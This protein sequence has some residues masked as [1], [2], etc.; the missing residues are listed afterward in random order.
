MAQ[1][2]V[3]NQPDPAAELASM[4]AKYPQQSVILEKHTLDVTIEMVDGKPVFE[5]D[6]YTSFFILGDNTTYMADSKEYFSSKEEVKKIEAYSLVPE[7]G[8]YKELS[9]NKFT[10][11]SEMGDGVFFDDQY[12]YSYTFP[13]VVKGVKTVSHAQSVSSDC[14]MPIVFYFGRSLPVEDSRITITCPREVKLITQLFGYDTTQVKHEVITKGNLTIHTWQA[15]MPKSYLHDALAP[16]VQHYTPHLVVNVDSYVSNGT[17]THV[18]GNTAD[19]YRHNYSKIENVNQ[20]IVPEIQQLAD[21]ITSS[22]ATSRDKVK[23]IYRWVQQNIKYVAIEDGENGMVPREA[24]LVLQRRYGDCKDKS[25]I[26]VS[27]M[28]AVHLN[29]SMVWVGTRDLPYSYKTSPSILVDNHMIACWWDENNQPVLLDGTSLYHSVGE[30]PAFIQGKECLIE[31]GKD[32]FMVYT[33]PVAPPKANLTVDSLVLTI[34]H[35]SIV[36][37]G[38]ATFH[39]EEKT[40]MMH[41]FAGRDPKRFN[42][43]VLLRCPKATNKYIVNKTSVSDCQNNDQ[44][45]TINYDF[46]LPD[47]IGSSNGNRYVNLNLDRPFQN[48]VINPDRWLPVESEYTFLKRMVCILNVPNDYAISQIPDASQYSNELFG[49]TQTYQQ[50][51]NQ[52]ILTTNI[53]LNF[54]ILEGDEVMQFRDMIAKLNRTC[55]KSI[56]LT[57]K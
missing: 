47:Y 28:K 33:I 36:G 23:A 32:D 30:I 10:K 43:I 26:L 40:N 11:T 46:T 44:P 21:S 18:M 31:K 4:Q 54:Q 24:N 49:F 25:S 51:G 19:L 12:A 3:G 37:Q 7:G 35:D 20:S 38:I 56:V 1:Q 45:F 55:L 41:A 2:M 34:R 16:S 29:A 6:D 15:S 27:L 14:Y 48:L 39:G 42:D 9:V 22:C 50:K 8:K 17:V 52:V 5:H 57:K 53:K 13:S